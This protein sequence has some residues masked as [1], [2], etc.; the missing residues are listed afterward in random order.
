MT[1][2][3]HQCGSSNRSDTVSNIAAVYKVVGWQNKTVATL[4]QL[5][6][7]A[8]DAQDFGK[9]GSGSYLDGPF[10][11]LCSENLGYHIGELITV[12]A[13]QRAPACLV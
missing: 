2:G 9:I 13:E 8:E 5:K 4:K 7:V 6:V 3:F 11:K 10:G 1:C 12:S